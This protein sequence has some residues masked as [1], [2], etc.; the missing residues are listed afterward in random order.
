MKE[1]Y[2]YTLAGAPEAGHTYQ[3]TILWQVNFVKTEQGWQ[4]RQFDQR[5]YQL[6]KD[7]I[8]ISLIRAPRK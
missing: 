4:P 8:Q 5:S 3:A 2:T 6:K 1:L 7:G